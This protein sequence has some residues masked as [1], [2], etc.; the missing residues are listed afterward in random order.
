VR[1]WDGTSWT[2]HGATRP[3]LPR[4]PYATLPLRAAVLMLC[5]LAASLTGNRLLLEGLSGLDLPVVVLVLV[6]VLVGY[7]P[8]LL[9]SVFVS[10]RW[11]TGS[12]HDD[13]GFRF[14]WVDAGW[15]PLTWLCCLVAQIAIGVVVYLTGIP[16]RSNTEGID[17]LSG[18]RGV[19]LALLVTAVVAAPFVEELAFRGV[20][21]KGFASAL[22]AWVAVGLQGVLFGAAH[23]G[24][25]RGA[26]NIGLVLVLAGVGIVLGGAAYLFRRLGPPIIAH[27]VLNAVAMAI[28][29]LVR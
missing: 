14:R 28:V 3:I 9:F 23:V 22:P 16:S 18:D 29:L 13:L 20:V 17:D 24:P 5:V 7:G 27:G 11:G 1:W 25:E 26:G 6:S 8:V 12:L 15:G 21:L 10:R 4:P 19:L 2:H